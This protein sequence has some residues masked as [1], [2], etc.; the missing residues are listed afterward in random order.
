MNNRTTVLLLSA[1]LIA[2]VLS[3]C[4]QEVSELET[5][6]GVP[7]SNVT[8]PAATPDAT[9]SF[10]TVPSH[11]QMINFSI[12][13]APALNQTAV[14]TC[15]ILSKR[16]ALNTT[17]RIDLPEGFELI[18]GNLTW[19]DGDGSVTIKAVKTGNWTITAFTQH[20]VVKDGTLYPGHWGDVERVY[21]GVREDTAWIRD[22]DW[23][24]IRSNWY[25]Y[26]QPMGEGSLPQ[27]NQQIESEIL[28]SATPE[29]NKE[30]T[31]TY[32]VTP[33]INIPRAEMWLFTP[34]RGFELVNAQLPLDGEISRGLTWVGSINKGQT[35]EIN[36][37]YRITSTGW[38]SVEGQ[39]LVQ[40]GGEVTDVILDVKMADLSVDKG[41]GKITP[42]ELKPYEAPPDLVEDLHVAEPVATP[43]LVLPPDAKK[44]LKN[45]TANA[46]ISQ[47][48]G[49]LYAECNFN[50]QIDQEGICSNY[51]IRHDGWTAGEFSEYQIANFRL[52]RFDPYAY[53]GSDSIDFWYESEG[54]YYDD[55]KLHVKYTGST[56][57]PPREAKYELEDLTPGELTIT[58][59]YLCWISENTYTGNVRADVSASR[60]WGW[61]KIYDGD[62]N[63]LGSGLTGDDGRF[64]IVV[65]NPGAT[66]F[67]VQTLPHNSA[68]HVTKEDGSD[69]IGRFPTTGVRKPSLS[70]TTYSIGDNHQVVNNPDHKG[71]WRIYE[72]IVDDA[73][74]RGAWNFLKNKG[75]GYTP[76]MV[77]VTFPSYCTGYDSG[78]ERILIKESNHT[79]ALDVV[80]HEYG[81][82]IM[83]MLYGYLP[84]AG[85][86]EE[87]HKIDE[88]WGPG[89]SHCAWIEGWANFFPLAVQDEH[90]F[91]WGDGEHRDLEVPTWN[92]PE[93]DD[94]DYVEGRIA[95]A[96]NDIFD[97]HS[98]DDGYDTFDD[99]FLN[100]WEVVHGQT[101]DNFAE[102]YEA[103]CG[104]PNPPNPNRDIPKAN[105]A[106]FQNTIDYNNQPS[107]E[108][109]SPNGGGW[110]SGT[111]TVS[112]SASDDT[113]GYV[114]GTVSQVEFEYYDY[115]WHDI[116]TDT[117][118][119]GG[120][121][122]QWNTGSLTDSTVWVRARAMDNLG[123]E[124]DWDE[125]DGS[126][127][128]DNTDPSE[129][130][131]FS[132]THPDE[133]T[134]YPNNAPSFEWE[135]PSDPSG[136]DGYS[137]ALDHSGST[138]P[139]ETIDTT[140]NSKA[141]T[142]LG[143]DIWHFHVRA[144]DNAGNWGGADH[145]RVKINT[146]AALPDLV[147]IDPHGEW[148]D[149]SWKTYSII[150]TVKNVGDAAT[151][152]E[153][154][155]NFTE[156]DGKWGDCD[157]VDPVPVPVLD[158]GENVTHT[159]GPFVM[160]G[161]SDCIEV[162]ADYNN[163]IVE[164]NEG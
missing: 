30:I 73:Y 138:I 159:V 100:I 86:S 108:I 83:D 131:T 44:K 61:V 106:I 82:F 2:A 110:Y 157:C 24:F 152:H 38:G 15:K 35:I 55:N 3:G 23:P 120:W 94:G 90:N 129:P 111:I 13:N 116:G 6:G 78:A 127:G 5:T 130:P 54:K 41:G 161:S 119:T 114:D 43:E 27:N 125:S 142:D 37:T 77:N 42:V 1:V 153:C 40:P 91:E 49:I 58:G 56:A 132:S 57:G 59:G 31:I 48:A 36:A 92:D 145:Y 93:W 33:S 155:T 134:W 87:H 76:P 9:S 65:T 154:W 115:A 22:S 25:D 51:K 128:V 158:V 14:L 70:D 17:T 117:S 162:C 60:V 102:F 12:S 97:D 109:T 95:G 103:W 66:G 126:F 72:T 149:L 34:P 50:L 105:A 62:N 104:L 29:L 121:N 101:D 147:I 45:K 96:L 99:D 4:V 64:S 16:G 10:L 68:C 124:S 20:H 107:C 135:T 63:F 139:D 160:G 137:Y 71:A 7:Q 26:T 98:H 28:F 74:D 141:Y 81:H 146:S 53:L 11:S 150:Y 18:S 148:I 89:L 75:P 88:A 21:V 123:E 47:D 39:L 156:V 79:K 46:A 85:C 143:D 84:T 140:E 112:A 136:I 133:N 122:V 8:P 113:G 19:A 32:R 67:Y 52:W 151:P 164:K 69:Y 80:Q 144:K 163:T 118:P